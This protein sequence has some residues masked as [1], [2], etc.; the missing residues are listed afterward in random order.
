MPVRLKKVRSRGLWQIL[1]DVHSSERYDLR[2]LGKAYLCG[3]GHWL[4]LSLLQPA[5]DVTLVL[6]FPRK[7]TCTMRTATPFVMQNV[8]RH[9]YHE[10]YFL[11][12]EEL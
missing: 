12:E 5:S 9:I 6:L 2:H 1:R 11:L 3:G 4:F 7:E 10:L 8:L